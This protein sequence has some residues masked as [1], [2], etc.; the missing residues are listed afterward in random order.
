MI[1]HWLKNTVSKALVVMLMTALTFGQAIP[2]ISLV[3]TSYAQVAT[4]S[5]VQLSDNELTFSITETTTV[6]VTY[7]NHDQIEALSTTLSADNTSIY[8]GTCSGTSCVPH[9]VTRLVIRSQVEG[10]DTVSVFY[11]S[12]NNNQ[13]E[14]THQTTDDSLNPSTTDLLWLEEPSSVTFPTA[15][16]EF[17]QSCG[18]D[19]ALVIDSSG[20]VNNTELNTM[21]NAFSTFIDAFLPDTPTRMAVVDFD[22]QARHIAGFSNDRDQVQAAISSSAIRSGGWT[23]WEDALIKAG[24][25]FANDTS[26][27]PDL[28]IFA[29]DGNPTYPTH[30][31]D[32]DLGRAITQA[33]QL[34]EQG[35]RILTIGIG[36][37]L[38]IDNLAQI[39]GSNINSGDE[40]VDVITSDFDQLSEDLSALV[41]E[42]CGGKIIVQKELD[43]NKNG[44]TEDWMDITGEEADD[45][46]ANWS[47]SVGN[48]TQTTDE[49]GYLE[50]DLDAGSYT[51][52]ETITND[53]YALQSLSCV[54]NDEQVGS[55][56][57]GS[58]ADLQLSDT[59]VI[60]CT[61]VNEP[62]VAD[63]YTSILELDK[64]VSTT[65]P[66]N[67]GDTVSFTIYVTLTEHDLQNVIITDNLPTGFTLVPDSWTATSD[68]RGDLQEQGITTEAVYNSPGEWQ[69]GDMIIGET[70]TITL[71]AI[72]DQAQ[73]PGT[74]TSDSI[75]E[76]Y[77]PELDT[78][79]SNQDQVQV[80]L[81]LTETTTSTSDTSEST[82]QT[83]TTSESTA[84]NQTTGSGRGGM[85]L[86]ASTL[87]V[88]G[89][90][91]VWVI[92]ALGIMGIGVTTTWI[93]VQMTG[94]A[95]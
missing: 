77:D 20:S 87:P 39:S 93:G 64:T 59:E 69:V 10:S 32:T 16:P 49:S 73:Q 6:S 41:T 70:V 57:A 33:N 85:I 94:D 88:T 3:E 95:K 37:G 28:I 71:Q 74:Y 80:A 35:I 24:E 45:R 30:D 58:I 29:S 67:P 89:V 90:N 56:N 38:N 53:A 86:G 42:L 54:K 83:E 55:F 79:Q 11:Y 52:S 9:D 18:L 25:V 40:N 26:A 31:L 84:E 22:N 5:A 34:K 36:N 82:T 75:A 65:E 51:L 8:L 48:Q 2:S 12:V 17:V 91:P 7:T 21:R 14:L 27:K 63:D 61:A 50:F 92:L 60:S 76:G 43:M 46:L 19:I 23:N 13:L 72:S 81:V 66:I 68:V 62:I 44:S 1:Q 15:N 47:F 4:A 78:V